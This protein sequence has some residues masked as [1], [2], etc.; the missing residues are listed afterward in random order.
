MKRRKNMKVLNMPILVISLSLLISA[1]QA[2]TE[3]FKAPEAHQITIKKE[4]DFWSATAPGGW[5]GKTRIK[6]GEV[7]PPH[8]VKEEGILDH[9]VVNEVLT[10]T[11]EALLTGRDPAARDDY[12]KMTLRKP[13]IKSCNAIDDGVST[14]P[15]LECEYAHAN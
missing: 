8:V 9:E 7:N 3:T 14:F 13:G 5:K 15:K 10:M 11:F 2:H 4:G 1:A 12:L 6:A